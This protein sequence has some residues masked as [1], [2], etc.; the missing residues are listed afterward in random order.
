LELFKHDPWPVIGIALL[1]ASSGLFFHMHSRLEKL[2]LSNL[3]AAA[4]RQNPSRYLS[5][6]RRR[7]WPAWPAYLFWPLLVAGVACLVYGIS[8]LYNQSDPFG[9][10]ERSYR[11][12]ASSSP[13]T[14]SP[15]SI[16]RIESARPLSPAFDVIQ[17]ALSS[18]KGHRFIGRRISPPVYAPPALL[19]PTPVPHL[20]HHVLCR[21]L[22]PQR[23]KHT[24]L[25]IRRGVRAAPNLEFF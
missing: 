12:A 22:V 25:P 6:A 17:L 9:L 21:S 13:I 3:G 2:G 18:A 14:Q 24:H 1:G 4:Q 23:H 8:R 7:G 5:E 11:F 20:A 19:R 10:R 15:R 16:A